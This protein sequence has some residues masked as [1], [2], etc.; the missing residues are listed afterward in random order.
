MSML[1]TMIDFDCFDCFVVVVDEIAKAKSTTSTH[2][3]FNVERKQ[4][5]KSKEKPEFS[6]FFKKKNVDNH[7][8]SIGSSEP[9]SEPATATTRAEAHRPLIFT[10][11]INAKT[12]TTN[13][14]SRRNGIFHRRGARASAA[15]AAL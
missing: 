4:N 12:Q 3:S 9:G 8:Y 10:R 13:D 1:M 15:P 11:T 5:K 2:S 7:R 14:I 6:F